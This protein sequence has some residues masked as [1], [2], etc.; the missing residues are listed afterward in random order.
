MVR[1]T[2]TEE[3]LGQ[4]RTLPREKRLRHIQLP[5]KSESYHVLS[6]NVTGQER[7]KTYLREH[8]RLHSIFDEK[9]KWSMFHKERWRS[10]QTN[11]TVLNISIIAPKVL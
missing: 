7:C 1:N 9:T 2:G 3:L 6:N 10:P 11:C 8:R 5:L 4:S